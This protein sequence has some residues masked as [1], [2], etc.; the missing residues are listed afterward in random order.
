MVRINYTTVS[1]ETS[2]GLLRELGHYA[3]ERGY[4]TDGYVEAV[5]DREADFPTGLEVPTASFDVAIPHADPEH[6]ETDALVLTFPDKPVPFRNM[7]A[8]EE[9]IEAAAV[10]MLLTRDSEGYASFLSN[11]ANLFQHDEFAEAVAARD[12]EQVF[13]LIETECL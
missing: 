3:I 12:H 9:T 5:L 11:L 7:E 13:N 6:V 8:P 2:E 1:E 10:M 4:A